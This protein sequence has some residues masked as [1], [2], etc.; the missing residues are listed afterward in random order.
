LIT[1]HIH[2]FVFK[3]QNYNNT[4]SV[5]NLDPFG[6]N[7]GVGHAWKIYKGWN[8]KFA[9]RQIWTKICARLMPLELRRLL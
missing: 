7:R 1:T 3:Y 2:L 6:L 4:Q 5:W 8:R 9:L